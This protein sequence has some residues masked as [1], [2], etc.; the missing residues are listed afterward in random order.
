[1]RTIKN[2]IGSVFISIAVLIFWVF[3]L[4]G[5]EMQSYLQSSVEVRAS[6]LNLKSELIQKV[7]NLNK[8]YQ[9]K[10]NELKRLSL[11]V[12]HEKNIAA[13]LTFIEDISSQNGIT[14][15]DLTVSDGSNVNNIKFF[16]TLS[17]NINFSGT[18][19]S[20][21]SFL[22]QLERHIRLVD[23]TSLLVSIKEDEST[24]SQIILSISLKANMYFLNPAIEQETIIKGRFNIEEE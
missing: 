19:E 14:L 15:S 10:F 6:A 16:N 5:Y 22:D 21:L 4:P 9:D 24:E 13:V 7:A 8:E 2:I 12:P 11:V 3:I 1:M 23:A 20:L 18:Y 17:L